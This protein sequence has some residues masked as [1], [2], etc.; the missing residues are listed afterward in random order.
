M[1]NFTNNP[2][3]LSAL[4]R[5]EEVEFT[6]VSKKYLI[7]TNLQT[8]IFMLF[9]LAGYAVMFYYSFEPF[10]LVIFA[11]LIPL[12]FAFRFWNNYKLQQSYGYALREKD[13]LFRRGFFIDSVTVL[14]FNRIPHAS[15]SRDV[16]DKY[17]GISSLQVFTA[18]G[19]GSDISIPGLLPG[20]AQK[21]KE[22]LAGKISED[23]L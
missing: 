6:P 23:E 14:P 2:I 17:L 21:L 18:G 13:I 9:V 19:S 3:D 22:V 10:A 1:E 5:Y 4:P 15:I 12:F 20:E 11:V 8:T 16:M 7:K